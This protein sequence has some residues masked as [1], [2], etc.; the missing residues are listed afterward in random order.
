M[1][2]K[3]LTTNKLLPLLRN[4]RY[5]LIKFTSGSGNNLYVIQEIHN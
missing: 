2:I 5:I 4:Y 1:Y 3:Y